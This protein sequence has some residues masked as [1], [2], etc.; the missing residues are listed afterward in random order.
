MDIEKRIKDVLSKIKP[1]LQNDG[2]DIEFEKFEDGVVYITVSGV[3][4]HC[5]MLSQTLDGIEMA[6]M[7][8]IPEIERVELLK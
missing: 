7:S 4:A 2:G 1:L 5:Y 6:L 3:C 8:E